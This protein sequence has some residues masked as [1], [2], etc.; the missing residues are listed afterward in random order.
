MMSGAGLS[1]CPPTLS[2]IT[3]GVL[4]NGRAQ[5]KEEE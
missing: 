1:C 3:T 2:P 4:I 5:A